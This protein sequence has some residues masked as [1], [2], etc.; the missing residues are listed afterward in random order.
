MSKSTEEKTFYILND[1][2]LKFV[3]IYGYVG[4]FS[5][6][7]W[8][9][10]SII[11]CVILVAQVYSQSKIFKYQSRSRCVM[12]RNKWNRLERNYKLKRSTNF[13]LI[14]LCIIEIS[15]SV[16]VISGWG[17]SISISTINTYLH[18]QVLQPFINNF[19]N[20]I[21]I[22]CRLLIGFSISALISMLDIIT[23]ITMCFI[24]CYA[25]YP[26]KCKRPVCY[27]FTRLGVKILVIML[28]S[29]VVQLLI[30]Q[31]VVGVFLFIYEYIRLIRLS[32]KLCRLLHQRYFDARFHEN[33]HASVVMYYKQIHFE[34]KI[35]ATVVLTS[36][37]FHLI[38]FIIEELYPIVLTVLTNPKW[39]NRVYSIPVAI[40][41][42]VTWHN[43]VLLSVDQIIVMISGGAMGLGFLIIT[44]PY[45]CV[46]CF[47][48]M[49]KTKKAM[50][51]RNYSFRSDLIEKLINK[52]N[53]DYATS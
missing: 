53:R 20:L 51:N 34:F 8:V 33:H 39:F 9:I 17:Y 1:I 27:G 19:Q 52:H 13:L 23:M 43:W 40:D 44:A 50:K 21:S 14:L 28:L 32:Y 36:L 48:F 25:F 7:L 16:T 35:G 4:F 47:Y 49:K 42:F 12:D 6:S 5:L 37:F 30:F 3:Y 31:R 38:A 24:E 2:S 41:Y 18:M 15:V 22:E 45:L 26:S 29:S 46:T 10:L 11:W